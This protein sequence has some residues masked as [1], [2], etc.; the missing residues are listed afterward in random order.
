MLYNSKIKN[1][2]IILIIFIATLLFNH[3]FIKE[4]MSNDD[5][6]IRYSATAY[7]FQASSQGRPLAGIYIK[8]LNFLGL[9]FFNH[10]RYFHLVSFFLYA[11]GIFILAKTI[12]S[13][14]KG[15]DFGLTILIY[16]LTGLIYFN[17]FTLDILS[18]AFPS[19]IF[20]A[21]A[22]LCCF[23]LALLASKK[24]ILS[25]VALLSSTFFYQPWAAIFPAL[26]I[27]LV[28]D[29]ED[30]TETVNQKNLLMPLIIYLTALTT[31]YLYIRLIHQTFF[32]SYWSDS[33]IG[34][35]FSFTENF[36]RIC[37][38]IL[39]ITRTSYDILPE[40]YLFI[41][42]ILLVLSGIRFK[43][44]C[45][46]LCI[47]AICITTANLP[48]LF[49]SIVD[50][51]ARSLVTIA[52]LPFILILGGFILNAEAP[53]LLSFKYIVHV[54]ILTAYSALLYFSYDYHSAA[55]FAVN[56]SDNYEIRTIKKWIATYEKENNLKVDS[57][58]IRN[59][60]KPSYCYSEW[61]CLF[62][63]RALFI[64][65]SRLALTGSAEEKIRVLEMSDSDYQRLFDRKNYNHFN[66]GK[67][68]K[69][70]DTRAYLITY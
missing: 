28:K 37:S 69:F 4:R 21:A 18:Y 64:K 55:Q 36:L 11:L 42:S 33:R 44:F 56:K 13:K 41:F 7:P 6:A 65:W 3:G 30:K 52:A 2:V 68:L 50:Y 49:T 46:L 47:T 38:E 9:D 16:V 48:Y 14:I 66:L 61:K 62:F 59:D 51:S 40:Y 57:F 58:H 31:N 70:E 24:Y 35:D 22:L 12:R 10:Q 34:G 5:Y 60:K 15:S 67:Q 39:K 63:R 17:F 8:A 19:V 43:N 29:K 25:F 54:A 23:S 26:G 1:P 45:W 20:A 27:L 53:K 32:S